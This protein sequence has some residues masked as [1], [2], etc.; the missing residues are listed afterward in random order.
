MEAVMSGGGINRAAMEHGIPRTTRKDCL[1]GCVDHGDNPG[2]PP[3]LSRKE[4]RE[5]G[6]FLKKSTSV[7]YGKSRQQVM[8]IAE[9]YVKR[10]KRALKAAQI[11]QGWWRQFLKQQ[12]DLSLRCGDI[13]SNTRMDAINSETISKYFSF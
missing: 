13:T 11:T 5:L 12:K 10:E 7:W 8:A 6:V 9:A 2:P 4:E 3:Y 1:S